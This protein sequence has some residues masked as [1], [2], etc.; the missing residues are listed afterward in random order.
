MNN[1][2]EVIAS[3]N[4]SGRT[5]QVY[6]TLDDPLF[7]AKEVAGWIEHTDP[8]KMIQG[9]E[10]GPEKVAN[11]VPTPG[12]SQLMNFLTEDGLYEVL[13]LS[14]KPKAKE[15]KRGVKAML[16]EIRMGRPSSL[17]TI[18][19]K[20]LARMILDAEEE[21][22]RLEAKNKGYLDQMRIMKPKVE[23]A[24]KLTEAPEW[25]TASQAAKILGLDHGRNKLYEK[26][27]EMNIFFKGRNEPMQ[28]YVNRGYFT[29]REK[30]IEAA[31]KVVL[32]P[33][34]SNKG[35]EFIA[36][37]LG[38]IATQPQLMSIE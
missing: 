32:V 17:N 29:M 15:W 16:K 36:K 8:S 6:G 30:H 5:V 33:L 37:K 21:R 3:R 7:L 26:L 28:E 13:M 10:E 23:L 12:G 18:S 34:F 14:R 4:I 24:E 38:I 35:I 1:Q 11:I 31:E 25:F 27:R 22:E 20:D 19:R 9:L 2:I